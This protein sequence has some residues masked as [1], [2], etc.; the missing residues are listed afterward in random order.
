MDCILEMIDELSVLDF[1]DASSKLIKYVDNHPD[2]ILILHQIGT[3]PECIEHDS[4]Q[5]KLFSKL[6]DAVLARAFREI[7]LKATVLRERGDSA[8]VQAESVF[9]GYSLVADAKAFRMSRTAKNQKDFKV[10]A[11]SGWRKD[12]DF[13]IL[14]SP[15]Y[16]YPASS[17]QIYA[18]AVDNNVCLF[19]WEHILFLIENGIRETESCNLKS[20]WNISDAY[21]QYCSVAQKKRCFIPVIDEAVTGVSGCTTEAFHAFLKKNQEKVMKRAAHEIDY[22]EGEKSRIMMYTKDQA[23][24]EL[25]RAKKINEKIAQIKKFIAGI[26]Q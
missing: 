19:S 3:I 26:Q 8:D 7:G 11:L 22:W 5:E 12:A 6:S 1:D 2:I 20:L 23:I 10:V 9:H 16:Q 24:E 4:T 14:C 17:S 15:Y 25:I 13:A 18:Q 21:A